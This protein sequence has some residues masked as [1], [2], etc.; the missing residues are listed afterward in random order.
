MTAATMERRHATTRRRFREYIF[1]LGLTTFWM[2]PVIGPAAQ[3]APGR[4]EPGLASDLVMEARR[5]IENEEL[6][7]ARFLLRRAHAV[8]PE[9]GDSLYLLADLEPHG[10]D[11]VS[12]RERLLRRAFVIGT[13]TVSPDDVVADLARLLIDTGRAEEAV[14][15][16]DDHIR[17]RDGQGAVHQAMLRISAADD[18]GPRPA[19]T[20]NPSPLDLL[21]LEAVLRSEPGWFSSALLMQLRASFPENDMLAYLDWNR[22]EALTPSFSDWL[23]RVILAGAGNTLDS[24]RVREVVLRFLSLLPPDRSPVRRFMTDYYYKIGGTD[25]LPAVEF[26]F[27]YDDP[28][29]LTRIGFEAT[30]KR[31]WTVAAR[32]SAVPEWPEALPDPLRSAVESVFE[33]TVLLVDVA[34][35]GAGK[36]LYHVE[37]GT[38]R[39]W[40]RDKDGNGLFDQVA[41]LFDGVLHLYERVDD[42][43][44][45]L[46]YSPYPLVT[47]VLMI[48]IRPPVE[49]EIWWPIE[50]GPETVD[51]NNARRWVPAQPVPF[52]PGF[53]VKTPSGNVFPSGLGEILEGSAVIEGT[54]HHRFVRQLASDTARV[55]SEFDTD[56][57]T[58]YLRELGLIR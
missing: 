31:I 50:I 16:L 53:H 40:S 51:V 49:P 32:Y 29:Y 41:E 27:L 26:L 52:D 38:V 48:P 55:L 45:R 14:R 10:R 25:P 6:D 12:F 35:T 37:A 17:D 2:V 11:T 33:E 22:V 56:E 15:L 19:T 23:G 58:R 43:I 47:Q 13:N 18:T 4:F 1:F 20:I 8:D 44:V 21:F 24:G 36:D 30:D 34:G 5:A 39:R 54:L 57:H 42:V 9:S 3:G 28:D 7:A 46:D